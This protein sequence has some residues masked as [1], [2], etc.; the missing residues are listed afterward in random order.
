MGVL[1]VLPHAPWSCAGS[2]MA[3]PRRM[4]QWGHSRGDPSGPQSPAGPSVPALREQHPAPC[5]PPPGNTPI[6]LGNSLCWSFSPLQLP[7]DTCIDTAE[8]KVRHS[9]ELHFSPFYR[10][11]RASRGENPPGHFGAATTPGSG[12][13]DQG[14][15]SSLSQAGHLGQDTGSSPQAESQAGSFKISLPKPGQSSRKE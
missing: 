1:L 3:I 10:P 2:V 14:G 7:G 15:A 5:S 11:H 4:W 8:R 6:Q 12:I 9:E 13:R